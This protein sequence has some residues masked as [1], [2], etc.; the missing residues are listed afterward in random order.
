MIYLFKTPFVT[1]KGRI[2]KNGE[3]V[4]IDDMEATDEV[5]MEVKKRLEEPE[6]EEKPKRK[7]VAKPKT[8]TN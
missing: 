6:Q 4:F 5:A 2:I 8:N 3:A 7:R 1:S